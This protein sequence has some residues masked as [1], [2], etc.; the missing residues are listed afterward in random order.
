MSKGRGS[1]YRLRARA[2][3]GTLPGLALM[4]AI[5]GTCAAAEIDYELGLSG[6][7]SSNIALSEDAETS[8]TILAPRL[9]FA[10]AQ[11]GSAFA[12]QARGLVEHR[13]YLDDTFPREWRGEL[14]GQAEWTIAPDRFSLVLEDYLSHQPVDIGAGLSP[15]N[16]Q[17]VNVFIA[18][19]TFQTRFNGTTR[20]QLDV[21][22][23]KSYAEVTEEFNG[24][25]LSAAA[26]LQRET[27][28]LG[29][30]ALNLVASEVEFDDPGQDSDYSRTDAYASYRRELAHGSFE[31]DLGRSWVDPD[32]G[33]STVSA[34]LA[35]AGFVWAPTGRS[36]FDLQARYQ[37]ADS[38]QELI[39]RQIDL[40][41]P[42]IQELFAST[43]EVN[44]DVHRQRRLQLDYRFRG[45]RLELR[46][47]PRYRSYR[48][49]Q[50]TLSDREDV[51]GYTELA[52]RI[53]PRTTLAIYATALNR[54]FMTTQRKD[55]DRIYG[56]RAEHRWTRHLTTQVGFHRNTRDST[57]SGFSY[58]E[59]VATITLLWVR[60]SGR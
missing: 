9:R 57:T 19:P 46:L 44:A 59:N 5:S 49:L 56:I 11:R 38:A 60:S 12:L 13:D 22:A 53:R 17:R 6:A 39:I 4:L 20:A 40:A 55:R 33:G 51:S 41:E 50:S 28:S 30:V 24:D 25:R 15:G 36:R 2:R 16:L 54:E 8:D 45:D 27:G 34:T 58:G 7:H 3:A 29:H 52:Y 26:R 14:A 10:V 37:L 23:A 48:Y 21:R 18:G 31:L 42:M 47:R 35:R 1:A 43:L 32:R